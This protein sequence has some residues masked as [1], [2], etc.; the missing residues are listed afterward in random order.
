[1]FATPSPDLWTICFTPRT[2]KEETE[3]KGTE[4]KK[5]WLNLVLSSLNRKWHIKLIFQ[6]KLQSAQNNSFAKVTKRRKD[7]ENLCLCINF[8][9]IQLLD[10]TVTELLLSREQDTHRQK[11]RLKTLPD[12]ESEYAVINDLWFCIQEDPYRVRFP[13][14]NGGSNCVPIRDLSAIKKIKEFGM[15]VHLVHVDSDEFVYKEIDRPL[16]IPRDSE[17]LEQEL[18]NLELMHANE[19]VVRL[20]AVVVSDN[21]YRTT[22]APENDHPTSLQGIL[23]EYHSNGILQNALESPKP[24]YPWHRWA[25]QITRALDALHQNGITHMDLKPRNIVLSKNED[26]I[27][28]DLSG[29][30]GTTRKWLS[31]EM[32]SLS[33][34]LSQDIEARKQND[35]WTLGL[36]LSAMAHATC[37]EMERKVLS[38]VSLLAATEVLPRISLQS[39]ISLL[40]SSL[41]ASDDSELAPVNAIRIKTTIGA[42]T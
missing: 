32:I 23:L 16:Y 38:K 14:Y 31:P 40:S 26:A 41:S 24:N 20:T 7:L 8:E 29:I 2:Y 39:A 25:L 19:G 35:I 1:M 36:I 18:R 34:P 11:L 37:N 27:L 15:G 3:S 22:A 13:I 9:S 21:P 5:R 10:D 17:V 33:E 28:I 4:P 6:G 12:V 30:G 42:A